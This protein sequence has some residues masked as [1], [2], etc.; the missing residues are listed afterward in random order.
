MRPTTSVGETE[1]N[2]KLED[3]TGD[4]EVGYDGSR[5]EDGGSGEA[6]TGKDGLKMGKELGTGWNVGKLIG[7]S[8]GAPGTSVPFTVGTNVT[9]ADGLPGGIKEGCS[10]GRLAGREEEMPEGAPEILPIEVR[11]QASALLWNAKML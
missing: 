10:E 8:V 4:M 1:G 5:V 2:E 6:E 7:V 11:F 9:I 3:G